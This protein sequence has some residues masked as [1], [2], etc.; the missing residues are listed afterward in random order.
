MSSVTFPYPY[1]RG[2]Q[3]LTLLD[4]LA[5]FDTVDHG[6]LI[7]RLSSK[8]GFGGIPLEWICSYLTNRTQFV[9]VGDS[10]SESLNLVR[11]VPRGCVLGPIFFSIYTQP[12]GDII[13]CHNMQFHL[14]ANDTQLF[15]TF[16][17]TLDESKQSALLC[18]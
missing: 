7:N 10:K 17:G 13:H 11:G 3:S 2:N 18:I 16:D 8:L 15:L 5:A 4:L 6:L 9:S 1:I 14:H 12:I